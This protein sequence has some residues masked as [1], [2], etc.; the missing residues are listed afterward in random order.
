MRISLK[1]LNEYV[2]TP[3][4]LKEF[5]DRLDLTGTGVEGI[6]NVG[7]NFDKIVT[8]QVVSKEKHPD[9]DHMWVC[10]VDVGSHNVDDE[11]NPAPLQIVCG[12]QNFNEGD[13]IVTAL[14]GAV[15]PGNFKIKRSKLRGVQSFG[16]NCSS[17]ELGLSD[18]HEGIII[19]PEDAPIGMPYGDYL[20]LSDTIL[21]LEITPNRP[22]C[23]SVLGLAREVGAMYNV[24]VCE[25]IFELEEARNK[26]DV[27]TLVT[28]DIEDPHR[29]KRYTARVIK[30]VKI[31]PSPAWLVER[32]TA[33]GGRSINNVVDIT[34]Y[35]LYL[36]GQPLHAFDYD[37]IVSEDGKAHIIVRP[38]KE[39]ETITTLDGVER[40]LTSDMT[41]IANPEGGIAL[42]GVMG[43]EQS[44]VSDETTTIL[45]ETATFDSGHTSRTSRNL[46]LMSESSLR[47]ERIVD[48]NPIA[49]ISARAAALLAE[50]S[51]GVVCPGIVDV[52]TNP[53]MPCNLEFR[54]DRFRDM[55]GIAIHRKDII[56]I[57]EALDCIV[58]AP[59]HASVLNVTT[60]TNRPD[61][62]REIDLYEEVLR[63]WGMDK[64]VPTLPRSSKRVGKLTQD[65]LI[66]RVI[67]QSLMAHGLHETTTY[68]FSNRE[69]RS[70][71]GI[72]ADESVVAVELLNPMTS[73][74]TIMREML[75]P[76]LMKS[77]AYNIAHGT[78]DIQLYEYGTVFKRKSASERPDEIK[79][80]GAVLSGSLIRQGWN[81]QAAPFDFF[82]AK[83]IVED[84]ANELNV[85]KVRFVI[86]KEGEMAFLQPGRG[87]VVMSG[88]S[89]LGWVG[90]IHP[91]ICKQCDIDAPVA[92]FE[93]DYSALAKSAHAKTK[94]VPLSEYPAIDVDVAFVVDEDVTN[95][96][97]MQRIKSAGSGLLCD[98][99]LFDVYRDPIKLGPDKKSMAYS[100][101]Y[102][103]LDRTL[104]SE[105]VDK[106]R[107]KLIK[108]V[109]ASLGA[110]I[111]S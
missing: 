99:H 14:I 88:K 90:E 6:E 67:H 25:P 3:K 17:K 41:L 107:A 53:T 51:G 83:G 81:V 45:L 106:A 71:F 49:D 104:T 74:H 48:D 110:Q 72:D 21:D 36:Y 56:S 50:V 15:L 37:K 64:V 98:I 105:E 12:A 35:I 101:R 28:V 68:S 73:E 93:L 34:N 18:D 96:V 5:C 58:D 19:L 8:A 7:D 77:V 103:S 44:E 38:A 94:V 97:L 75:L 29:C 89:P 61:L 11:G 85:P 9:S 26:P 109:S 4:S 69:E 82:D 86:P 111:R 66:E 84:L 76:G 23:M 43:G 78:S 57:L 22:D 91:L 54:V 92:A 16:M 80:I 39:G 55:M 33:E 40:T 65:Q 10:M 63:I 24:P 87:A 102:Q 13:H 46:R 95:E 108:K 52:Y 59:A 42:A 27:S 70:L 62:T 79:K 30:N 1:W 31:G 47:Y 20:G 32:I 2:E 60:P 100:L